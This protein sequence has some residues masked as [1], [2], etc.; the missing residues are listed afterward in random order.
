[1]KLR[2]IAAIAVVL[3]AA[4]TLF[5]Q[6]LAGTWQGTLA[7]P[8]PPPLRVVFKI[9]KAA[10]GKF[11]GQGFS[12]DQGGQP[13]PISTISVEGRTVKFK[14]D[15]ISASYEGTFGPDGN[16]INGT[17]TQGM[18]LPLNLTR[19]TPATAWAIPEP[20]PPPKPMDPA[21][22]PGI[23]VA[24][25]KPSPS[26]AR[27]RLYTV[28]GTQVMAIN[29][30]LLNVITFAYDLHERQVSGGPAWMST[31][32][33]EIAIKPDVPGQPNNQQFKKIF[34]KALVDRFQFKFHTEKRELSVYAI[35][36]PPN[37]KHKLTES[38]SG[39]NLPNLIFPRPGLL[40]AQNA[41]MNE[42][43][44]VLQGAVMDR[45]VVNQTNIQGRYNFTLDWTPDEFQFASF[46][47]R[48][49]PIPDTG[50][51]NIFQAFQDQL[52]LKLESTRAPAD[53]LVIDKAE[54][55]SEN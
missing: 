30:T 19:A 29:V 38:P 15:P 42:F 27:G 21:A 39:S 40:P 16:V 44:S 52:G 17:M 55:P 36:L 26:D 1:M 11:T 41:T 53:V 45:P 47:P 37:T 35:T 20:P 49:G 31:E 10:D 34:Q 3:S 14:I 18:P 33:F 8:G 48:Q 23:E 7:P 54:K 43:A 28:R 5:A 25:V 4:G 51:P 13:I 6:D 50:K 2:L 22:D 24:T 12:I 46:G 9:T 32:R